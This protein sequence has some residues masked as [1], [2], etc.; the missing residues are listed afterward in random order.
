M[1]RVLLLS[2]DSALA[3]RIA[4]AMGEHVAVELLQSLEDPRAEKPGIVVLDHAALSADRSL[5]ASVAATV[6]QAQGKTIV[7]ATDDLATEPVL[8][9][10]RAGASD[11]LPRNAEG[12]EIAAILSR[13][14]NNAVVAQGLPARLTLVLGADR[15]A[16]AIAATDM[17]LA[18]SRH[19]QP[20]LLIDCA[21]PNS[22]AE[23]YL[24]LKVNYGIASAV[25]DI[26]RLD[27]SLL[28]DALA[29]HEAT[30]LSLLTLDGGTGSEPAGIA[31]NDIVGLIRLLRACYGDV[32]L[33]AGSLRHAGLL[34][35][36]ALQAHTIEVVCRQSIRELDSCRRL[37]DNLDAD[38]A[39]LARMRLLVWDHDPSI[40]LDGQRMAD[41][42]GVRSVLAIGAD[43]AQLANAF[44]A[45]RP[46]LADRD[47]GAYARAILR[48]C[49]LQ[50]EQKAGQD[51]FAVIRRA[52]TRTSHERAA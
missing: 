39:A 14:I 52:L 24:D 20:A 23:T 35:E 41:V 30:G 26:E 25:A 47:G 31:P 15:E 40:L 36:M 7:L 17:A 4:D 33:C 6:E 12:K 48:A 10:M 38:A 49:N 27:A 18:I 32:V 19:R 29:R 28:A 37:L 42:L 51:A 3:D 16:A 46:L 43:R 5:S 34:R 1:S 45:G 2:V 13:L 8:Q 21:L 9:A 11:I 22:A 44:N 50:V